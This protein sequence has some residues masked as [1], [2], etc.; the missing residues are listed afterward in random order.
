MRDELS[1]VLSNRS[2]AACEAGDHIGAL[3]DAGHVIELRRNWTKGHF[4]RAK[5]L[6]GLGR[7]QEARDAVDLGLAFEPNNAVRAEHGSERMG[8]TIGSQELIT[9]RSEIVAQMSSAGMGPKAIKA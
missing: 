7:F 1:A 9:F 2:A 4:R 8:L 6:I 3:V 5:A